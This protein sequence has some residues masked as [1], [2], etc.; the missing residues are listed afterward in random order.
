MEIT[1]S[2]SVSSENTT[3]GVLFCWQK[4]VIQNRV[5]FMLKASTLS[6]LECLAV[7][8]AEVRQ[9]RENICFLKESG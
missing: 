2:E 5:G 9:I 8:K 7:V 6:L 4:E 3:L 1:D